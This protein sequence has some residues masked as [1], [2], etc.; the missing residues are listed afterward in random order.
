VRSCREVAREIATDRVERKGV[1]NRL[2]VRL[3]LFMCRHCR[4]YAE[5][6]RLLGVLTRHLCEELAPDETRL[7]ELEA[8]ILRDVQLRTSRPPTDLP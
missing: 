6:I 2:S 4:A 7:R 3:H 1:L 8:A 5:Q